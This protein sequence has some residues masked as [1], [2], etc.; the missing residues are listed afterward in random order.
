MPDKKIRELG[1]QYSDHHRR[2]ALEWSSVKEGQ[3]ICNSGASQLTW[4]CNDLEGRLLDAK[5]VGEC[6]CNLMR[7]ELL[8]EDAR[9]QLN[10][11][12]ECRKADITEMRPYGD[13]PTGAS[14]GWEDEDPLTVLKL[15]YARPDDPSYLIYKDEL[16]RESRERVLE[17]L[18][19]A[20]EAKEITTDVQHKTYL[21]INEG[22]PQPQGSYTPLLSSELPLPIG[23]DRDQSFYRP[24]AKHREQIRKQLGKRR[25][26]H[27]RIDVGFKCTKEEIQDDLEAICGAPKEE[28]ARKFAVRSHKPSQKRRTAI[29]GR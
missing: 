25:Y 19:E 5:K 13:V 18:E 3:G 17:K 26:W 2:N 16:Y 7:R 10:E 23:E 27:D 12:L 8:L 28:F 4:Q 21:H 11:C 22:F 29:M 14:R 9:R 20:V 24:P 15:I 6:P 1:W